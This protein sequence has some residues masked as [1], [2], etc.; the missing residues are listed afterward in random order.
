MSLKHCV[1]AG[2]VGHTNRET[3]Y[4]SQVQVEVYSKCPP[5]DQ[6]YVPVPH[7]T[8]AYLENVC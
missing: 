4:P 1:H 3:Q 5:L 6:A 2:W 7:R 8:S